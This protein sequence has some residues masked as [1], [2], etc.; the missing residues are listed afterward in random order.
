MNQ[1]GW[2]GSAKD[3]RARTYFGQHFRGQTIKNRLAS[4]R[5]REEFCLAEVQKFAHTP[6]LNRL[7]HCGHCVSGLAMDSKVCSVSGCLTVNR[8]NSSQRGTDA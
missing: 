1:N 5:G 4:A 8:S 6:A 2:A 3:C 7:N